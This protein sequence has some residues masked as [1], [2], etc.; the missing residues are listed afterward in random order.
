MALLLYLIPNY[1]QFISQLQ[2][3]LFQV[4]SFHVPFILHLQF[5]FSSRQGKTTLL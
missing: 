3:R 5:G 1:H 2:Q 4:N